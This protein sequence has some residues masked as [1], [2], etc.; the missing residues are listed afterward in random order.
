MNTMLPLLT[1][2]TLFHRLTYILASIQSSLRNLSISTSDSKVRPKARRIAE[3]WDDE[4][5]EKDE[6]EDDEAALS[7]PKASP[8]KSRTSE[9]P[10]P[11]PPT[12]S[13]PQF[14]LPQGVGDPGGERSFEGFNSRSSRPDRD[15]DAARGE[16][17]PEKTTSTASRMIAAGLG[18]KAPPRTEEQKQYDRAMRDKERRT[19]DTERESKREAEESKMKAKQAMWDD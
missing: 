2:L 14:V 11:P 13:S 7:T 4:D 16:T 15:V 17:R 5:E 9:Y 19:R 8:R 6:S 10:G 12:P 18:V 3:S 1:R